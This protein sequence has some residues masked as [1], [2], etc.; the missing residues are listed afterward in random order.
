MIIRMQFE[1]TNTSEYSSIKDFLRWLC[2]KI[3]IYLSRE[4]NRKKIELRIKY[5]ENI[6]W[7]EWTEAKTLT[8][9]EILQAIK[10]S[11]KIR[12]KNLTW[13]IYFDNKIKIPHTNTPLIKLISFIEF[14]DENVAGTGM[15]QYVRRKFTHKQLNAWWVGYYMLKEGKYPK[16]RIISD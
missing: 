14:G 2:D 15:F 16:S 1:N 5:I 9:G 10:S 4:A 7:I 3:Y 12:R 11:F 13:E 8:A 6:S